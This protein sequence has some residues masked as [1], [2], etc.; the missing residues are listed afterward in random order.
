MSEQRGCS[1]LL[2]GEKRAINAWGRPHAAAA[3]L[4]KSQSWLCSGPAGKGAGLQILGTRHGPPWPCAAPVCAQME[5]QAACLWDACYWGPRYWRPRYWEP[6][7][8]GTR[9]H[10]ATP[11][12]ALSRACARLPACAGAPGR[13]WCLQTAALV[14]FFPL[15]AMETVIKPHWLH[16]PSHRLSLALRAPGRDVPVPPAP[17][18]AARR[19]GPSCLSGSLFIQ[20]PPL[21]PSGSPD[22][23]QTSDWPSFLP[24]GKKIK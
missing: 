20:L 19:A 23:K 6:H 24:E 2:P 21:H 17:P 12:P 22:G 16:S 7:S 3:A 15:I 14:G 8:V 4:A 11:S 5:E 1:E 13:L 10:G 18:A 9:W